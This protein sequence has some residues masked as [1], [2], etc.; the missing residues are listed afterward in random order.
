MFMDKKKVKEIVKAYEKLAKDS[1]G[2]ILYT[3]E[4]GQMTHPNS[5]W[6]D[7]SIEDNVDKAFDHLRMY[8]M[9]D[10]SEPHLE[11]ALTRLAM[12]VYKQ[13]EGMV[14]K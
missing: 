13:D 1:A 12:A 9:R 6:R 5:D 2:T 7:C 3:M 4:R 11:H 14:S 8:V 10:A